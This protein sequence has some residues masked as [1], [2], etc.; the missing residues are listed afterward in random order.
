MSDE[1]VKIKYT[2]SALPG[3]AEVVVLVATAPTYTA[4]VSDN[5]GFTIA[6]YL[7][8]SKIRRI[9]VGLINDQAG[10]LKE[11]ISPDRGVTWTQISSTAVAAIAANSQNI[12]DFLVE[13]YS[14]WKLE[15]T[16]GAAAQTTFTV[17]IVGVGQRQVAT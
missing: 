7:Q 1:D 13:H 8:E 2:G 10:T 5:L 6:N 12:Y 17:N 14:D 15:W 3:N 16:N 9:V 4:G 11:Y